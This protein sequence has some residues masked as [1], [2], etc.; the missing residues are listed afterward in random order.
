MDFDTPY[1]RQP[2]GKTREH[3]FEKNSLKFMN[4]PENAA[5][6]HRQLHALLGGI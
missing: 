2:P 6:T 4:L 3:L 1:G 5:H